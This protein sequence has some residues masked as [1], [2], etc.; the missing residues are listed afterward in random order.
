VTVARKSFR[1]KVVTIHLFPI[2]LMESHFKKQKKEFMMPWIAKKTT[3][4]MGFAAMLA[5][6]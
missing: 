3:P 4:N 6:E 1:I 5:D 2:I